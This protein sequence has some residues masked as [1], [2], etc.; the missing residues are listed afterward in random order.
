MSAEVQAKTVPCPTCGKPAAWSTA[1]PFRP[2]C[3]ER[4]KLIDLGEWASGGYG[5]P[6]EEVDNFVPPADD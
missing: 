2:F 3:N 1:N 4:C 5:I 6:V